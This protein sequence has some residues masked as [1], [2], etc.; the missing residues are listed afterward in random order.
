MTETE[1]K[2]IVQKQRSYFYTGATLPVEKRLDALKKLKTCIQKYEPL[3]NEALKR[4]LGK[5]NFESYICE[6]GLVLSELSYMIRHTPSYAKEKTVLTPLAQFAS[7]SYKKPSPYGVVLVMSPW[8]Y[9]FL[10]TIDPLIDAIAAGNTVV[11]K[12]S[13]YSPHTSRVIETIITECFDPQYV[14]V[15]NGGRAEN[16]TLLNEHFDYIFFTGSQHVGRE[17]MAKAS[18]HLTP[19]T[20][21]MNT[22]KGNLDQIEEKENSLHMRPGDET[23]V[24]IL[25]RK[26]ERARKK[27]DFYTAGMILSAVL[28]IILLV[29]ATVF[30]DSA[31]LELGILVIAALGVCV[32]GTGRMKG[33]RELQKRGRM[34]AKWLS[35]QQELKKNREELQREYCERE[36]SLGNLQEEYREYEDRICLTAREEIDIKALN[37]A[38]GVIKKYSEGR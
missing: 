12:P 18:V 10:L 29:A 13:A 23:G 7:R 37:L 11:L 19:V 4:D 36:V 8:N 33:A 17:V 1:I 2:E 9:P 5:S 24:A 3:I 28:G 16:N 38:M 21:E 31:V 20:L 14:A 25:D 22:L 35:R 6:V 30:T 34:K 15:V 26:T 32:F 27:R